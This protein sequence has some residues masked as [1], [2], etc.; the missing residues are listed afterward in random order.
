MKPRSPVKSV[1]VK[2]EKDHILITRKDLNSWKISH[3]FSYISEFQKSVQN[4]D[5]TLPEG[6]FERQLETLN[7]FKFLMSLQTSR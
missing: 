7:A 4:F 2:K 5:K 3:N 1:W 6:N